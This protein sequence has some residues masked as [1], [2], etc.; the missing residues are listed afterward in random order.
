MWDISYNLFFFVCVKQKPNIF[1]HLFYYC[2]T[3]SFIYVFV[4]WEC[5]DCFFKKVNQSS[6]VLNPST[7]T[8]QMGSVN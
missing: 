6:S 4:L 3:G 8:L 2:D 7:P 1:N 5:S